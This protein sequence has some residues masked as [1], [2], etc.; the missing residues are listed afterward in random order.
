MTEWAHGSGDKIRESAYFTITST[1]GRKSIVTTNPDWVSTCLRDTAIAPSPP[2]NL[3]LFAYIGAK[4]QHVS[5]PSVS[6]AQRCQEGSGYIEDVYDQRDNSLRMSRNCIALSERR[7]LEVRIIGTSSSKQNKR[8]RHS[9]RYVIGSSTRGCSDTARLLLN[10]ED[11]T[12][13]SDR[14]ITGNS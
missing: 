14:G 6:E 12:R 8:A 7:L 1:P 10:F 3:T 13:P 2:T 11:S 5:T 9:P 4:R